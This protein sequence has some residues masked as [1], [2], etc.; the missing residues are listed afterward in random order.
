MSTLLK[1]DHIFFSD[2]FLD[3]IRSAKFEMKKKYYRNLVYL[4][5]QDFEKLIDGKKYPLSLYTKISK[6]NL[7]P[8][9]IYLTEEQSKKYESYELYGEYGDKYVLTLNEKQIKDTLYETKKVN[10]KIKS[11][12]HELFL[13]V[14]NL[15][16]ITERKYDK[17]ITNLISKFMQQDKLKLM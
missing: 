12:L 14:E 15:N 8:A 16:I 1:Q 4:T 13:N 6:K 17:F 5:Q 11:F 3:I 10:N 9:V 7:L 2:E